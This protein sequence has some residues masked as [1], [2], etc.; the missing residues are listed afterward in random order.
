MSKTRKIRKARNARDKALD[1]AAA[2]IRKAL[3]AEQVRREAAKR[4]KEVQQVINRTLPRSD[5]LSHMAGCGIT[6]D[7]QEGRQHVVIK[8]MPDLG[9][10]R[11]TKSILDCEP[12][13]MRIHILD[14]LIAEYHR[15]N[16]LNGVQRIMVS[17][18]DDQVAF[19]SD[20]RAVLS[21]EHMV[22]IIARALTHELNKLGLSECEK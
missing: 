17:V 15:Y 19:N 2:S 21:D 9:F 16:E 22:V 11:L 7:L 20:A 12:T 13:N 5:I 14:V 3:L 1:E 8:D 18:G 4:L 6:T 10:D